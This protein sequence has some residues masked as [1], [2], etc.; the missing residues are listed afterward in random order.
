MLYPPIFFAVDE[1]SKLEKDE[2]PVRTTFKMVIYEFN[3]FKV[4]YELELMV[5]DETVLN[6]KKMRTFGTREIPIIETQSMK[7]SP[8]VTRYY[9]YLT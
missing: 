7:I 2:N 4:R 8:S 3:G 5:E 9:L 1:S 6:W